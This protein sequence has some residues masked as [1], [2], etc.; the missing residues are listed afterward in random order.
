VLLADLAVVAGFQRAFA[1]LHVTVGG[2]PLF[3]GEAAIA[4][5]GL[6]QLA[7]LI[8]NRRSPFAWRLPDWL[9]LGYMVVGTAFA[10]Q[11]LAR[12][13][14]LAALRDYAVVYYAVF[15]FFARAW[16]AG[17]G[18]E[19]EPVQ[20]R[21]RVRTL[22]LLWAIVIG[23]TL[24]AA[25]RTVTFLT[26]PTL[27][28]GHGAAGTLALT[29]W[30][31]IVGLVLVGRMVKGPALRGLWAAAIAVDAFAVYLSATRTMLGV[32]VTGV[33]LLAAG[34]ALW[35]SFASLRSI[36][37]LIAIPTIAA[38]AILLHVRAAHAPSDRLA[39]NGPVSLVDGLSAISSRWAFHA[40]RAKGSLRLNAEEEAA[41]TSKRRYFSATSGGFLPSYTF[42]DDAWNK[43]LARIARSPLL[44]I[45]FGPDAAVSPDAM[46]DEPISPLSNCGNAHNTYLTLAMR[47]GIPM[48]VFFL[49]INAAIA[50]AFAA[51]ARRGA[52]AA[53]QTALMGFV[54]VAWASCL[55]YALLNLFLESPYL[56]AIYWVVLAGLT[57]LT[58]SPAFPVKPRR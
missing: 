6:I 18:P 26:N 12:G 31:A 15:Y 8:R 1:R 46:C 58:D 41:K 24:G 3:T 17:A 38:G 9:L 39:L 49:L 10:V 4:V 20:P 42:R 52:L 2:V 25:W 28:D 47:M 51:R 56:S 22:G 57:S 14:G 35:P 55:A 23:A 54:A 45:G 37:T 53:E 34:R 40:V 29:A 33:V 36:V 5:L 7:L 50:I 43:A 48:L 21:F 44:G 27:S 13:F 16:L 19:G 30:L 32:I 11:G